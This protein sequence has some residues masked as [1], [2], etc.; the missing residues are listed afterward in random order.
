[1]KNPLSPFFR[2]IHYV[3]YEE[4][5][6][7]HAPTGKSRK[8]LHNAHLI[9]LWAA[10]A[11]IGSMGAC[12]FILFLLT[13]PYFVPCYL[14]FC[15]VAGFSMLLGQRLAKHA[16]E[17]EYTKTLRSGRDSYTEALMA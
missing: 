16:N 15:A 5:D 6:D 13:L 11:G 17:Q 9:Q 8:Q 7:P 4:C 12:P 14:V 1:M 3:L 2:W 10:M